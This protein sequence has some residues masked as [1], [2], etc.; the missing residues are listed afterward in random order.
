MKTEIQFQSS[1][2]A[3]AIHIYSEIDSFSF[4]YTSPRTQMGMFYTCR[5]IWTNDK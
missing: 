5:G 2:K 3:K 1:V 4:Q